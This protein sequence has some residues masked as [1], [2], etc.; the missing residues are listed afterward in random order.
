MKKL[1]RRNFLGTTSVAGVAGLAGSVPGGA[2]QIV[3]ERVQSVPLSRTTLPVLRSAEIVIAGGSFAGVAAALAFAK[4]KRKVILIEPRTYLGRE[5][6]ATLRPWIPNKSGL[7]PVV[8]ACT[9]VQ[10]PYQYPNPSVRPGQ[11]STIEYTP[12]GDEMALKPDKI[13]LSLEDLLLEAGVEF[14]YASFPVGLCMDGGALAGLII[15]N[16]SSRQVVECRMIVDATDTAVVARLAGAEFEAPPAV[17]QYKRTIEFDK[18]AKAA[19]RTLQ[20]PAEL[21]IEGNTVTVHRGYRGDAHALVEFGLALPVK[22]YEPADAMRREIEARKRTIGL[23]SFLVHQVP[24]FQKSFLAATSYELLG[25]CTS[26]M[27]G[28]EPAWA[29]GLPAIETPGG[30]APLPA[31]A[32]PVKGIWCLEAA[33][34]GT[35]QAAEFRDPIS[36]SLTGEAFARATAGRWDAV[37]SAGGAAAP[38]TAAVPASG[39][40]VRELQSPQKGRQYAEHPVAPSDVPVWRSV[41][42]LVVG[43]GTSGATA[44]AAAAREGVKTLVVEMNP[45]LG[46]TGTIAGV[47]SYWFGRRVGFVTRVTEKVRQV[48]QSIGYQEPKEQT[49][50]WNI[51]AKM[52][53]LLKEAEDA[54][55]EVLFNTIMTGAIV[56]GN[57][58]RGAVLATRYGPR[59]VLSKV[60]V[61]ATGD[62]DVAAFAGAEF[63]FCSAMDHFGMW[64]NMAQFMTPGRNM[65]HFMSSVDTAN[66]EDANRAFLAGRRRGLNA[67]DHGV[68]LAVRE[69]RH[70][71][72]DDHVTMTDIYRHRR[73]QDVVNIH[74]SNSDM[75][76]KTTSPWFRIGLISPHYEV[77]IPYG[78]LVPKRIENVLI[79]G[80]AFSTTHDALAGIRQQPD[81]ENLGGIEGLIAAKCVKEGKTPRRID[82]GE[83]QQRL[84]KEG[85]L[86][87]DVLTRKLKPHRYSGAQL[88]KL[89]VSMMQD[90]PLLAYQKMEMDE[91]FRDRIPFIEVCT[92]GPRVVPIL[93]SALERAQG[94]ARV[95]V[96]KAL[97]ICGSRAGAPVLIEEIN[98]VLTSVNKI[99][100]RT[101]DVNHAGFPPDM[102]AV[103]NVVFLLYALGMMRDKRSLPVWARV[104]EILDPR[105]EDFRDRF[106]NT[107]CYADAVCLGTERL[108][109]PDA[110]P[111]LEKLH[112]YPTLRN[113][114]SHKG[115]QPDYFRERQAMCELAIGRA[116]SRCGSVKGAAI[117]IEYLDDNRAALA[118]QAH[119]H[120]VRIAGRDYGK[121]ARAWTA[122]LQQAGDSLPLT[123]LLPDLDLDATYE[124]EILIS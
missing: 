119:S 115:A 3:T 6:T 27:K 62:G 65:N 85:I 82:V 114:V 45:G 87:A 118:E 34:W 40:E 102:G 51:E 49:L 37:A 64:F 52:F 69:S 94:G 39:L 15:A 86:P 73:W 78:A 42:V 38:V 26:R 14:F 61:D 2:S 23:V 77:E 44:A 12:S 47:D 21:G 58:V 24:A 112:A 95:V 124:P 1:S 70:V 83:V 32:G 57:H 107:F 110:I 91:V 13:K 48:H 18:M 22:E 36:A 92:A 74:Y 5:V 56:E 8:Q 79:A 66:I 67:H 123:P 111:I 53:A 54:G 11:F 35:A 25:P 76:G 117:V 104:V 41:D 16:K 96:A 120:L 108:A 89:V 101:N 106:Q 4:A 113:Q 72:G 55:A 33:R 9:G 46:G 60:I 105:E 20:V 31:L 84:V 75:K 50:R 29:K 30:Q 63:V 28:P 109:D 19:D 122:W 98:K 43:G 68:Y 7:P 116:L 81:L 93:E 121:S 17:A 10:N 103:P 99:P 97:A 71:L 59:A 88:R 80:K 90:Q 100:T